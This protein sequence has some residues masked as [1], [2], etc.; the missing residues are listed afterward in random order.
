[1]I[2]FAEIISIIVL[3]QDLM[4]M[5]CI[6]HSKVAGFTPEQ[7]AKLLNKDLISVSDGKN[8]TFL[9]GCAGGEW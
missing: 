2:S 8:A 3:N 6:L 1:M 7:A 9:V 4:L 5:V